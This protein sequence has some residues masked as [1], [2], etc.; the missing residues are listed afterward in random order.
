MLE[1]LNR[2][3]L[4]AEA[5]LKRLQEYTG[6]EATKKK[7]RRDEGSIGLMVEGYIPPAEIIPPLTPESEKAYSEN[8]KKLRDLRKE[9]DLTSV[10]TLT[11]SE[12]F[13]QMW[14][15]AAA[16]ADNM[17]DAMKKGAAASIQAIIAEGVAHLVKSVFATVPFPANLAIAAGIGAAGGGIM[18]ALIPSFANEGRV[19]SPT[20]AMVGDYPGA[21]TNPEYM[22]KE[23]TIKNMMG[24]SLNITGRIVAEATQLAVILERANRVNNI[25]G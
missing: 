18:N 19:T 17:A 13:G 5:T 6:P 24:G 4:I 20:L 15:Q 23:S 7:K 21:S 14:M 25:I 16:G 11:L 22:L 1:E 2:Q 10:D 8:V 9:I 3:I 12:N